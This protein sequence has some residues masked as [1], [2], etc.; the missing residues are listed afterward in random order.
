[1][2]V[3]VTAKMQ[4]ENRQVIHV[5]NYQA[6]YESVKTDVGELSYQLCF[7]TKISKVI[8]QPITQDNLHTHDIMTMIRMALEDVYR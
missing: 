5:S 8:G 3:H 7:S 1:M 4:K 6:L 2:E